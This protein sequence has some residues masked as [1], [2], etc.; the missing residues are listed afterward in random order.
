VRDGEELPAPPSDYDPLAAEAPTPIFLTM[1]IRLVEWRDGF[2]RAEMPNDPAYAN[3]HMIPHGGVM[4]TLMDSV[5]GYSGCWC[6]WPG[7]VRRAMTL[8]MNTSFLGVAEG[9]R[10]VGQSRVTGGGRSLFFTEM[11]VLD[12]KGRPAAR[13]SGVYRYRSASRSPY[14]EPL[15]G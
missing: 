2:C 4:M 14:G 15:E 10:L 11:T 1:G 5:G 12:D 8:S 7:R 13:A 9:A 3:R 6:P